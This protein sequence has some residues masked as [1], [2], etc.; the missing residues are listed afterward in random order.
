MEE[1]ESFEE[2]RPPLME[3]GYIMYKSLIKKECKQE[4]KLEFDSENGKIDQEKII[5]EWT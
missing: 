1:K 4:H 2:N 5:Y 3:G